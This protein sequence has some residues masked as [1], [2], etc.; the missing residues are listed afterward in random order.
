MVYIHTRTGTTTEEGIATSSRQQASGSR[1]QAGQD[2][3]RAS[4]GHQHPTGKGVWGSG[5]IVGGLRRGARTA[6]HGYRSYLGA[7][8]SLTTL[9]SLVGSLAI[10]Y[11]SVSLDLGRFAGQ[12]P[13]KP[14]QMDQQKEDV[15]AS[16]GK[17]KKYSWQAPARASNVPASSWGTIRL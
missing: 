13:T 10:G 15:L 11:H 9:T 3:Y 8:V 7:N 4:S 5:K 1:Q 2:H 17:R 12:V 16:P 14:W 6:S